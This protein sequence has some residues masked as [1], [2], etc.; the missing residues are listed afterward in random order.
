[1]T[2]AL[3]YAF[4]ALLLVL[5]LVVFLRRSAGDQPGDEASQD[6]VRGL[7]DPAGLNVAERIFDPADY[8]WLRD[9]VGFPRLAESL[10]RTRRQMALDW[11]RAVRQSFNE[12][13]R[14]PEPGLS[15]DEGPARTETG[16]MLRQVLRF[17]FVLTY[18]YLVVCFFGPYHRLVPGFRFMHPLPDIRL[19]GEAIGVTHRGGIH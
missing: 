14:T 4:I 11:L 8:F 16:A 12:L 19:Q 17:H 2:I 7:W 3:V 6:L 1:M 18:A 10:Y 13:L 9:Q 5:G 15:E